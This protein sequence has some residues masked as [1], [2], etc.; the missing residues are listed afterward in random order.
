MS[1]Q[2]VLRKSLKLLLG[3]CD[4]FDRRLSLPD[5]TKLIKCYPLEQWLN[6]LS[7]I[8]LTIA[9]D[10]LSEMD[11]QRDVVAGMFSARVCDALTKWCEQNPDKA[12]AAFVVCERQVSILQ[13]LAFLHAPEQLDGKGFNSDEDFAVLTDA[14][15]ITTDLMHD[16]SGPNE[17]DMAVI[18]IHNQVVLQQSTSWQTF[19]RAVDF[20]E[21]GTAIKSPE[22]KEYGALF[23]GIIGASID[24]YVLGGVCCA[25]QQQSLTKEQIH[26]GWYAIRTPTEC[27]NEKERD[28]VKAYSSCRVGTV[29]EIRKAVEKFEKNNVPRDFNLIALSQYPV[30]DLNGHYYVLSLSSLGRSLFDGAKHVVLT[31]ALKRGDDELKRV[32]GIYGKIF[33]RYSLDLLKSQ[34]GDRLLVI[35]S[36][37]RTKLADCLILFTSSVAVVEIK[38]ER[39]IS[40]EHFK[41][42]SR[43]ERIQQIKKTGIEKSV[44]QISNTIELLRRGELSATLDLPQLDWTITPIIPLVITEED[45]PTPLLF[46]NEIYDEIQS[47]LRLLDGGAGRAVR[48]RILSIDEVELA[49][50][51]TD[52]K[53]FGTTLC[54]WANDEKGYDLTFKNFLLSHAFSIGNAARVKQLVA[55]HKALAARLGFNPDDIGK[56]IQWGGNSR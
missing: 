36:D 3:Y 9:E 43:D 35:P 14:L 39:F 55:A 24:D 54:K 7:R 31:A 26:A 53:D 34:F 21:I 33:Q 22:T 47:R 50:D 27:Q 48:L 4:L 52:S 30:V 12:H 8:Q 11:A 10:R 28:I 13:E 40:T 51:V 2:D 5:L 17:N 44:E 19:S 23:Q 45:F 42:L 56:G 18:G 6:F 32:G 16:Y 25:M 38:S 20:Y 15:L 37:D 41:L 46:W 1:H 29:T 49:Q